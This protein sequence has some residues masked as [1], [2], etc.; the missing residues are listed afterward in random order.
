[1]LENKEKDVKH[2]L[3][4]LF[5][6]SEAT[7][8]APNGDLAAKVTNLATKIAKQ[9]ENHFVAVV[10]PGYKQYMEEFKGQLKYIYSFKLSAPYSQ[11][12]CNVL[13][14]YFNGV[15][16]YLLDIPYYF[17]RDKMYGYLDDPYRFTAFSFAVRQ[18]IEDQE[19]KS[20]RFDIVHAF[21][22]ETGFLPYMLRGKY[23][24]MRVVYT[25]NEPY[26][27]CALDK[28]R[29]WDL[30]RF[31]FFLYNDGIV[32]QN[33]Q[34][35]ILKTGLT[36][37]DVVTVSSKAKA[38]ALR[39]E[40]EAYDNLGYIFNFKGDRFKPL[41]DIYNTEAYDELYNELANEPMTRYTWV[42]D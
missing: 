40:L 39:N 3:P 27:Q 37:A 19:K 15:T 6:S 2:S 11:A 4:I 30:T 14:A 41:D 20:I 12:E 5:V 18:F 17:G 42:K 32:R 36:L 38:E 21:D 24:W 31:N 34:L 13:Q 26:F 29:L 8:F 33:N 23:P 16:Y 25:V 9:P 10:I 7:P 1:M 35:N 22:W 28:T